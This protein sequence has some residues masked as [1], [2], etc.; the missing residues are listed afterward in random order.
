M[1]WADLSHWARQLWVLW[2]VVL[3]GAVFF[4]AWRPKNRRHFEDCARIPLRGDD[5]ELANHE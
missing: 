3:L 1:S 2:L 5:E 4:H